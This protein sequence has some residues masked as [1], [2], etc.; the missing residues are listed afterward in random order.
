MVRTTNA[1][2]NRLTV[3]LSVHLVIQLGDSYGNV[4]IVGIF[5]CREIKLIVTNKYLYTI[6]ITAVSA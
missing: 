4:Q 1:I 2:E 6:T 5:K 3:F